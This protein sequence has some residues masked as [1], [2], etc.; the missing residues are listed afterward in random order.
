MVSFSVT[1]CTV[2]QLMK[3]SPYSLFT[4]AQTGFGTQTRPSPA[5]YMSCSSCPPWPHSHSHHRFPLTLSWTCVLWHLHESFVNREIKASCLKKQTTE[6]APA[7]SQWDLNLEYCRSIGCSYFIYS[8][9]SLT[10]LWWS[11]ATDAVLSDTAVY[12]FD[13]LCRGPEATDLFIFIYWVFFKSQ[14]C[15]I[16]DRKQFL[17]RLYLNIVFLFSQIHQEDFHCNGRCEHKHKLELIISSDSLQSTS[18]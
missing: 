5:F 11:L 8:G 18:K 6:K 2:L 16:G 10:N 3:S 13:H 1:N 7:D 15:N 17:T 12:H 9:T 14:M 4:A